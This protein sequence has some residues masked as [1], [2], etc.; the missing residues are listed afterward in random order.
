MTNAALDICRACGVVAPKHER[1]CEGCAATLS[2]TRR[3]VAAMPAGQHFAALRCEFVCNG[4][5]FLAP[6]DSLDLDGAVECAHCGLRQ[7]FDV[8]LWPSALDFAR[9]V[10]DLAGPS[11]EGRAPHAAIW[12]GDDNPHASLGVTSTFAKTEVGMLTVSAA[13]AHPVCRRC[14]EPV[15]ARLTRRGVVETRC[16]RCAESAVFELPNELRSS[17]S[18]L[19]VVTD[20][21]RSDR[22][23]AVLT[24][25]GALV[26]LQCP[27]CNAPLTPAPGSPLQTCRF[28]HAS[29]IVTQTHLHRALRETIEPATI[30]VLFPGGSPLRDR[31]QA[32]T[33]DAIQ[34]QPETGRTDVGE[35]RRVYEAPEIEGAPTLQIVV[36]AVI[37]SVAIL[38]GLVVAKLA[39]WIG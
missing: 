28:C 33:D 36:T 29:S 30:W 17:E 5:R 14:A 15:D 32:P 39:G 23:R 21:H 35:A 4:C 12:I 22:P 19:G 7:R 9:G 34:K 37:G 38:L 8:E 10:S 16:P 3:A 18:V 25:Q 27:Q 20:A 24:T 2:E 1:A 26:T 13:P 31:L 11:P 6:L